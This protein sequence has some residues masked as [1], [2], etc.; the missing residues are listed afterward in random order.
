MGQDKCRLRL[1]RRTLL[2]HVRTNASQLGLP[3]R[4][5]RKDLVPRCGPLGGIYSALKTTRHSAVLFLACDMPFTS[6]SVLQ[7]FVRK[8]DGQRPLF[9]AAGHG[10]GFP[11]VLPVSLL[12]AV[13]Q[14]IAQNAF[15][16]HRL[17][18]VCRARLVRVSARALFNINTPADLIFAKNRLIPA[19]E[20]LVKKR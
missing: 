16:L 8:F 13:E 15:S 18:E 5:L 12:P 1:G 4:V 3:L 2:G 7:S 14:L 9:A 17:A 6:S 10:P 19:Q 11:L 20:Q